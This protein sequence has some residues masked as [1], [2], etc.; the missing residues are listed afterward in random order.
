ML[1]FVCS[2]YNCCCLWLR[3]FTNQF[4]QVHCPVEHSAWETKIPQHSSEENKKKIR[5]AD[6]S[7]PEL[8]E[9][10]KNEG[11]GQRVKTWKEEL[12]MS[13]VHIMIYQPG[14]ICLLYCRIYYARIKW[15]EWTIYGDCQIL[16]YMWMHSVLQS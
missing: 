12:I 4:S 8:W 16:L 11:E 9:N 10:K 13:I 15:N 5:N 14:C 3:L 6:N 1:Q 7:T 2:L